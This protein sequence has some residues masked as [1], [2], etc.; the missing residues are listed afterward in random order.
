MAGA[1]RKPMTLRE[2]AAAL[3]RVQ[4]QTARIEKRCKGCPHAKRPIGFAV[5]AVGGVV[6]Q[7]EEDECQR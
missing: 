5:E 2:V 3:C 7:D 6:E 4:E 1:R